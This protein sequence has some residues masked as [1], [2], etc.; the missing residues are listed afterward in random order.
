MTV[1]DIELFLTS[2]YV[3]VDDFLECYS[4]PFTR[5]PAW[6]LSASEAITLLLFGQWAHFRSERDFY[7]FADE[8]LRDAFPNLP[9]REQLNRQW[10]ALHDA[11]CAFSHTMAD[12]LGAGEAAY[13]ALDATAIVTR[14]A[15]RRG[16]GWLV[17]QAD[18]GHSNRLGCSRGSSYCWPR[19]PKV[20]SRDLASHLPV[21]KSNP[22]QKPSL[23]SDRLLTNVA[24]P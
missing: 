13:E 4:L 16:N 9:A 19:H 10:R 23:H 20:S 11:V 7:R 14:S 15:K 12:Q 8:Q 2:L 3:L 24:C 17:G 18:I 6:Q 1:M 5:G 22:W 21:P